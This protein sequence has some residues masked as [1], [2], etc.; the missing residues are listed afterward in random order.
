[1]CAQLHLFSTGAAVPRT[2]THGARHVC[3]LS[4][5]LV[6]TFEPHVKVPHAC[7]LSLRLPPI[8]CPN[9][10]YTQLLSGVPD[11]ACSK[12]VCPIHLP[13]SHLF[14]LGKVPGVHAASVWSVL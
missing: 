10:F 3:Y 13:L 2:A 14:P 11:R 1:M 7:A 5:R 8:H 9:V 4:T 12:K 6:T